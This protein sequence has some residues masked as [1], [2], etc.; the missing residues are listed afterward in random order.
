MFPVANPDVSISKVPSLL[1]VLGGSSQIA[2]PS[3]APLMWNPHRLHV[4][5][6]LCALTYFSLA[7]G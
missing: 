1:A 3:H 6:K 2:P 7:A 4:F 5:L